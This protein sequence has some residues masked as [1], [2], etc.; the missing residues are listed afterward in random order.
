MSS[1]GKLIY[2]VLCLIY[3]LIGHSLNKQ[4]KCFIKCLPILCLTIAKFKKINTN[5]HTSNTWIVLGLIFSSVGDYCLVWDE[6]FLHGM[7]AFG[8]AH[9]MYIAAFR[10][11]R[12]NFVS[13]GV[14]TSMGVIFM[15][16]LWT[17]LHGKSI[18]H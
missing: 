18:K 16:I 17:R 4:L 7:A 5:Y 13:L 3:I 15:S 10:F 11:K 14:V 2:L 12:V 9:A 8:L 6:H 1:E